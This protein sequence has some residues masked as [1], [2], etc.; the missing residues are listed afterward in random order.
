MH[1]GVGNDKHEFL[2]E[3]KNKFNNQRDKKERH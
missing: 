2:R 3:T 1:A